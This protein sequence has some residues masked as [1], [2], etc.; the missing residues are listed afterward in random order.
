MRENKR[1]LQD[2][3][4][5]LQSRRL[6]S[7]SRRIRQ[8]IHSHLGSKD[9]HIRRYAIKALGLIGN[10][11]DSRRIVDQLRVE[12][13]PE[14]RTWGMAALMNRAEERGLASICEE[15]GLELGKPFALAARL[16]AR[17]EWLRGNPEI[18]RISI[19]D[20]D[21][22]LT[23][24]TYLA[25][26]G[27]APQDLFHPRLDNGLFLGELTKHPT[28]LIAEYSVWALWERKEYDFA[29]ASLLTSEIHHFAPNVRKWLY[30]LALQSPKASELSKDHI[31]LFSRDE[32][33]GARE[34]L[35]QG[36]NEL[37]GAE[38]GRAALEW[39]S[40]EESSSVKET[41][42]TAV[43]TR[44]HD[45]PES[46]E[47]VLETFSRLDPHH[48]LRTKLR[49]A[50]YGTPL[51]PQ[52]MRVV[53]TE[54]LPS[55]L[56][57]EGIGLERNPSLQIGILHLTQFSNNLNTGGG[58]VTAQTLNLGSMI[59]SANGSVQQL[60]GDRQTDK[61]ILDG[62][63][64]FLRESTISDQMKSETL[65]EIETVAKTPT[66]ENKKKLYGRLVTV[67][68]GIAAFGGAA[69]QIDHLVTM[70]HHWA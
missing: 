37:D 55:T 54:G 61:D 8:L 29:Q 57:L 70:A 68:Q 31:D 34:G 38:F 14:A 35:A 60:R 2:L 41:L 62:I 17:D 27:R 3:C 58:S 20:D 5:A 64:A 49:V 63:I 36:F 66:P 7:D 21:L 13:D 19:D 65:V 43:A 18:T 67:A 48:P 28:A 59:N 45:N 50:S 15:T 32:D 4:N 9:V 26:Y 56:N 69:F 24:A 40:R 33:E 44:A 42:L 25:G 53:S 46:A 47:F 11:D 6:L 30:K 22:T 23:W 16:Y 39:Y 12:I 10:V 51:Y 52:L 1:A